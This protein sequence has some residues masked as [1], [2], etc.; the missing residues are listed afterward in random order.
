M[1]IMMTLLERRMKGDL[2]ETFQMINEIFNYDRHFFN[3][4]PQTEKT[5]FKRSIWL[6][7]LIEQYILQIECLTLSKAEIMYKNLKLNQI[8]SE[9]MRRKKLKRAFWVTMIGITL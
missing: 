3:I 1:I 9:K 6:F 7:L 4:C 8:I 5:D 2:I